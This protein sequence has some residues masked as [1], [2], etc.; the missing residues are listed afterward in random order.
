MV[1]V[2]GQSFFLL[3]QMQLGYCCFMFYSITTAYCGISS[4]PAE[5]LFELLFRRVS[6]LFVFISMA[7]ALDNNSIHVFIIFVAVSLQHFYAETI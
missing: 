1:I 6:S 7:D 3:L 5:I 4:L 2:R